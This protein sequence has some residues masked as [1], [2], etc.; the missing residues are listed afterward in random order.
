MIRELFPMFELT[1]EGLDEGIRFL[2]QGKTALH[3][4]A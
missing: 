1:L 4:T 3:Q 2:I